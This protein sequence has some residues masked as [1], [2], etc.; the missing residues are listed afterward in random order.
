MPNNKKIKGISFGGSK[1]WLWQVA[2]LLYFILLFEAARLYFVLRNITVFDVP[3]ADILNSFLHGFRLDLSMAAYS[4]AFIFVISF[5]LFFKQWGTK[6]FK[7][8]LFILFFM[9]SLLIVFDAELYSYWGYKIDITVLNYLSTP[10]EAI[11]S[12]SYV[13]FISL[14]L[15]VI[16]LTI[17]FFLASKP[18]F[19]HVSLKWKNTGSTF[20]IY[21]GL[22]FLAA[23][24]SVDVSGVNI[25]TVYFSQQ[26]QLNHAAVNSGWNFLHS[27]FATPKS[28][29]KN[30][31][32]RDLE[33]ISN[34]VSPCT[35]SS[36]TILKTTDCNIVLVILESFSGGLFNYTQD[37]VDIVPN[38]KK[39]IEESYFFPNC[40]ATSN[41]SDKG[42]GAIF[43]GFPAHPQGTIL[44]HP[45]LYGTVGKFGQPFLEKGYDNRFYY[46]G[47]ADFANFKAFLINNGFP[48]IIDQSSFRKNQQSTKWGIH[49]NIIMERVYNDIS[50]M[51]QPFFIS[52]FTLSSHEPFD[53]PHN[54]IFNNGT[55][56]GDYLNSVAFTDSV[57][58]LFY[59]KIKQL[60]VW[61]NTLFIFVADHGHYHP[62][63][64]SQESTERYRI[65]LILSGGALKEKYCG[66]IN[67][68]LVAQTDIPLTMLKQ[69]KL[70]YSKFDLCNDFLCNRP[71]PVFY[72]FNFGFGLITPQNDTVIMDVKGTQ[73]LKNSDK[74]LTWLNT[75][76][77]WFNY[78]LSKF[79]K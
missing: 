15:I 36:E 54:S 67:S 6:V 71:M 28:T 37:S 46:G 12:V 53:V 77:V 79:S 66:Q 42:L 10:K 38:L 48:K 25:S 33:L 16:T 57:T 11:A 18:V 70:S 73:L 39:I 44:Q 58:G 69:F 19:N 7:I 61:D 5:L 26:Q 4:S 29:A 31:S 60:P 1:W 56:K 34:I 68:Q 43:S 32:H 40:Y 23:R 45:E 50:T 63:N 47:N 52:I 78:I 3:F 24:G 75:G 21:I 41:R 22:L 13:E 17:L 27:A 30:I 72:L 51:S 9:L 59:N 74:S 55:E 62:C 49:D 65:P 2:I 8:I 76:Q 64:S 14:T 20:I 35:D